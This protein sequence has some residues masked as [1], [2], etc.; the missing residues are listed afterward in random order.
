MFGPFHLGKDFWRLINVLHL[1]IGTR[2][3]AFR[4]MLEDSKRPVEGAAPASQRAP[5]VARE[6]A[7]GIAWTAGVFGLSAP[8]SAQ[9]PAGNWRKP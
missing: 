2:R 4:T 8:K 1:E 5:V 7:F 3:E 6:D 9:S